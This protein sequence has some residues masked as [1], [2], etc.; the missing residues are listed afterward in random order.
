MTVAQGIPASVVECATERLPERGAYGLGVLLAVV[1]NYLDRL[2]FKLNSR[3]IKRWGIDISS[4]TTHNI[5]VNV[6]MSLSDQTAD[7]LR[8]IRKAYVLNADETSISLNGKKVWVWIFYNHETGDTYIAVRPTRGSK[9]VDEVLG[10]DWKGSLVCDGLPSYKKY[11]KQRCW[12]HII[13]AIRHVAEHNP[14]CEAAQEVEKSLTEIL[15]I[16]RKASGSDEERAKIRAMLDERVGH[17]VEKYKDIPELKKFI[18]KLSNAR[19]DLFH[20][21]TDPRIPPTNNDAERG[22][23]EI[24]VH[25]KVRGSIRAENTMT[26]LGNLFSCVSTWR[27]QKMNVTAELAKC[28]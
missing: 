8:R 19:P 7:I 22:L 18:T 24:V 26:W 20:F 2:P 16:G 1:T 10:E 14:E 25:R 15:K 27:A 11:R 3:S 12:A 5:L 4:G 28:L 23:R 13:T 17:I 21:V 6:G 9:V